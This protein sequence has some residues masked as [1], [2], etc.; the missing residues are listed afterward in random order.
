MIIDMHY[1]LDERMEKM[2]HLL[3][4]MAQFQIKRTALIAPMVDPFHVAGVA[5]KLAHFV[6]N[7]LTG[8]WHP[9]G[10]VAYETTVT[11]SGKFSILGKTY[12]IDRLPDNQVVAHALAAHP[13]KF[14]GWI[15]IN[16]ADTDAV[17]VIEKYLDAPG[18]I[19]VKCHPFWHQYPVSI[20]DDAAAL[21]SDK[22]LPLLIHL[23]G[24]KENGD[25]RYLPDRHPDLKI[26]Y[27]HA[28]VPHY[29]KLW[30]DA[31][32]RKNVFIDLSSP[33][34]DEPLRR[35]AVDAMGPEKCLYGTDG[36]FGYPGEDELYDHGAILAEMDRLPVPA[37]QK[38]GILGKNFADLAGL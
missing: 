6:R 33:Y 31:K 9:L 15:F 17:S 3:A 13:D 37:A 8:F 36:P 18:W 26:I 11:K 30:D 24:K 34:L 12:N 10:K 4:Q 25:F 16:P 22:G 29:H 1:H 5:E 38:Q 20:L 14:Y 7:L 35:A 21:C 19:G 32:N 27:A 28:G 23:G 2:D